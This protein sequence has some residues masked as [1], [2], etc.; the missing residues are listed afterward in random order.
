MGKLIDGPGLTT[1]FVIV[2]GFSSNYNPAQVITDCTAIAL[3]NDLPIDIAELK[4]RIDSNKPHKLFKAWS[5]GFAI[6]CK[7]TAPVLFKCAPQRNAG[8]VQEL[9]FVMWRDGGIQSERGISYTNKYL[10]APVGNGVEFRDH[11][12]HYEPVVAA[13][14]RAAVMTEAEMGVF[15]M[16]V[17]EVLEK[18]PVPKTLYSVISHGIGFR[19]VLYLPP[20]TSQ[21]NKATIREN[22]TVIM[23]P[24]TPDGNK[25][26][27][28]IREA[29]HIVRTDHATLVQA[30]YIGGFSCL[31]YPGF[32]LIKAKPS[33]EPESVIWDDVPTVAVYGMRDG[34][35]CTTLLTTLWAVGG[36]KTDDVTGIYIQRAS[37]HTG[38]PGYVQHL[39]DVLYIMGKELFPA[40]FNASAPG[41]DGISTA[42]GSLRLQPFAGKALRDAARKVHERAHVAWCAAQG[43]M[44]GGGP[45]EVA[46]REHNVEGAIAVVPLPS[47]EA[48]VFRNIALRLENLL[49]AG[50]LER[51]AGVLREERL[52]V[53]LTEMDAERKREVEDNERKRKLEALERDERR[54]LEAEEA[55]RKRGVAEAERAQRAESQAT[56]RRVAEAERRELEEEKAT[57]LREEDRK[58]DEKTLEETLKS[59]GNVAATLLETN[60]LLLSQAAEAKAQLAAD[61]IVTENKTSEA[62]ARAERDRSD[63]ARRLAVDE[64]NSEVMAILARELG[65]ISGIN[66]EILKR[67]ADAAAKAAEATLEEVPGEEAPAT[68]QAARRSG[69]GRRAASK[70]PT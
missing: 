58:R 12:S 61:K 52:I 31:I 32:E 64:R 57:R 21:K 7:L 28:A 33:L 34:L 19:T 11:K 15:K 43:V 55:E 56:A 53:R 39:Q 38:P 14:I 48:Q 35:K 62:E 41:F 24:A 37:K 46:L 70:V 30:R 3:G 25:A 59:Q 17:M 29:L 20:A 65:K 26:C 49:E 69:L 23:V 10:I 5:S 1:M 27:L 47:S 18:L 22:V 63:V 2:S 60:R 40:D 6:V 66:E 51:K 4:K 8:R 54:R 44:T 9:P 67:Q 16:L 36:L 42:R 68:T 13:V 50:E 45:N